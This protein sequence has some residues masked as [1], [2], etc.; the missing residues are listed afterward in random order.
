MEGFHFSLVSLLTFK[1]H[2]ST[3]SNSFSFITQ[4]NQLL[5]LIL[6][7]LTDKVQTQ[8]ELLGFEKITAAFRFF[9]QFFIEIN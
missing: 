4:R 3:S 8:K 9:N 6:R 1:L 7:A 5:N 2:Y